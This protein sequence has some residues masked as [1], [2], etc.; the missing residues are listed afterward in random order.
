MS[1]CPVNVSFLVL[2]NNLVYA[3]KTLIEKSNIKNCGY[4]TINVKSSFEKTQ[5]FCE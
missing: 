1:N 5:K 4:V 2:S 3:E